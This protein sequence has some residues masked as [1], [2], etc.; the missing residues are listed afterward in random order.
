VTR[1]AKVT[2]ADYGVSFNQEQSGSVF[3][4]LTVFPV[5]IRREKTKQ[6]K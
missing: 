2:S 3:L 1:I 4:V 6:A 5:A